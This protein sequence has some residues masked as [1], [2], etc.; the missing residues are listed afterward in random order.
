MPLSAITYIFIYLAF[1]FVCL[2]SDTAFGV[3]LYELNYFF[4]PQNRWWF[5][6]VPSFFSSFVIS[7]ILILSFFLKREQYKLVNPLSYPT[8]KWLLALF[9]LMVIT[10]TWAVWP[11]RHW[12]YVIYQLKLFIIIAI[13]F[14]VIDKRS[15]LD[16][17]LFFYII[18][19]AYVSYI[20]YTVGRNQFGRIENI[21]FVDGNDANGTAT[22]ILTAIPV[23]IFYLIKGKNWQKVASFLVL[24]FILN[25]IILINS[26][27]AFLGIA[28][29]LIYMLSQLIINKQLDSREKWKVLFGLL[30]GTALF[31]Y[32]SDA[33]FWERMFTIKTLGREVIVGEKV[34]RVYF[35]LKTFDLLKKYPFGAGVSGYQFLSPTFLPEEYLTEAIGA[36]VRQ[37]AVHSTYFQVLAEYGYVGFFI[38]MGIVVSNL[39]VLKILKKYSLQKGKNNLYCQILALETAFI[40]YLIAIA[41]M[42]RLYAVIF[43]W[44]ILLISLFWKIYYLT[45]VEN[46]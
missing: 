9:T 29:G 26:R 11:D 18:G 38:F 1:L 30:L 8:F 25:A 22:V 3:Y 40:S 17:L 41:F 27:G 28:I 43:Y 12:E 20:A 24:P 44:Q 19:N 4:Y 2:I 15:R 34:G 37:R 6:Y 23:L 35:W 46:E 5:D 10:G 33:T 32:L 14:Q 13:S 21:G 16:Y 45:K 39:R 36:S 42:N 31:L 7:S